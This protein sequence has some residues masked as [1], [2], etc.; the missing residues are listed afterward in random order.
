MTTSRSP[1]PAP[2]SAKATADKPASAKAST[3]AKA[4]ADKPADKPVHRRKTADRAIEILPPLPDAKD[5]TWTPGD[6]TLPPA[7][8]FDPV[9]LRGG[10]NSATP[11]KQRVF[12][13]VLAETGRV[14]LAAK[15]AGKLEG[16]FYH[17]RCH[18][19]GASFAAAWLRALDFGTPRVLDILVDQAINGVPEYIY[20]DGELIGERRKF[21]HGLMMWLVAH[22]MPEKFGVMGG[23]MQGRG[24]G[25]ISDAA[26]LKQLRKEWEAEWK[27]KYLGRATEE[28]AKAEILRKLDVLGVRIELEEAAKFADD[29]AKRAA[30]ET[31]YG[32]Q[33][34]DEIAVYRKGRGAQMHGG[35]STGA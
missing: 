31:L 3:S 12:I 7:L 27:A 20:K 10:E 14:R 30:W 18:E 5:W 4:S 2:A 33:D 17:L 25:S 19:K 26:R 23:L 28:E 35:A 6:I 34:W 29:P 13:R 1:S 8:E 32:P 9:I 21:N 22:N 24:A 15:A 11:M 16:S